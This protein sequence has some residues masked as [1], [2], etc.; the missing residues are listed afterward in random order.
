VSDSSLADKF[1]EDSEAQD[2]VNETTLEM[3][4]DIQIGMLTSGRDHH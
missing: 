1:D 2:I 4:K 3:Q